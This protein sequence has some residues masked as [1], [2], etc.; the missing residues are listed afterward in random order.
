LDPSF[1]LAIRLVEAVIL[2]A[3]VAPLVWWTTFS[4][5]NAILLPQ[6]FGRSNSE[7]RS[8]IISAKKRFEATEDGNYLR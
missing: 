6:P 1:L 7:S 5:Y 8:E 2:Y 4:T 3:D